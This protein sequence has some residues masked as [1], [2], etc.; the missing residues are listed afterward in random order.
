VELC[1]LHIVKYTLA[2]FTCLL[3]WQYRTTDTTDC[4]K[5]VCMRCPDLAQVSSA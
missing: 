1:T 4:A 5:L 2:G 3:S